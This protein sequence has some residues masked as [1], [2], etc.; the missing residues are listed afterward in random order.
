MQRHLELKHGK[1]CKISSIYDRPDVSSPAQN[2]TFKG[3]VKLAKQSI[4][5]DD[6][7]LSSIDKAFKCH[8]SSKLKAKKKKFS[9]AKEHSVVD[10]VDKPF[11][12]HYCQKGFRSQS[13]LII[14]T[15]VHTGESKLY[16]PVLTHLLS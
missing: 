10:N 13:K 3:D 6:S 11:K 1:I 4:Q 9:S 7:K 12:C 5:T 14:H 8:D 16:L 2:N 15:R